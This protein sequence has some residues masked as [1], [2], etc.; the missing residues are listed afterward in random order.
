M[1]VVEHLYIRAEVIRVVRLE[2]RV[3]GLGHSVSNRRGGRA[4]TLCS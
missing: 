2:L 4:L 1:L 3:L